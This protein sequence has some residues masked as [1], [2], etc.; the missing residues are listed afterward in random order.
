[1]RNLPEI[2]QKAIVLGWA[3]SRF[4][5]L[6]LYLIASIQQLGEQESEISS[7]LSV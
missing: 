3:D 7:T 2:T 5:F 6:P 4:V 1:M